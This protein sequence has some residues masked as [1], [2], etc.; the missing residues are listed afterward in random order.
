MNVTDG[1]I[2]VDSSVFPITLILLQEARFILS[3]IPSPVTER[4]VE[5]LLRATLAVGG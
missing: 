1:V 5:I 3:Y 2:A 4:L